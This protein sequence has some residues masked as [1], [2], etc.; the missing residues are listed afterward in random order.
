MIEV[1]NRINKATR[2]YYQINK[3]ILGKKELSART[4]TRVHNTVAL[5]TM[6][7]GNETWPI[8]K[9]QV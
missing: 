7:Y 3:T 2:L 9:K 6:K 1:L 5:P 8:T 4:K